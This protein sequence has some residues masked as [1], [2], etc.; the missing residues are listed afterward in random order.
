MPQDGAKSRWAKLM[1]AF[2]QPIFKK[3][4]LGL[5]NI[6]A[7]PAKSRRRNTD[8]KNRN[9]A[10]LDSCHTYASDSPVVKLHWPD[11]YRQTD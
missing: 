5:P 6:N 11:Y 9:P 8:G 1:N 3:I 2:H 10:F 4:L 7:R